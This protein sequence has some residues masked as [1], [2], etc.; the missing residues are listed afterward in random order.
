MIRV[1]G[2]R[3]AE[4]LK[5]QDEDESDEEMEE[6]SASEDEQSQEEDEE[7]EEDE[8]SEE[9]DDGG[10][11]SQQQQQQKEKK[12]KQQGAVEEEESEGEDEGSESDDEGLDDEGL[13]DDAMMAMDEKLGA[14]VRGVLSRGG[15][16]GSARQ[17][18]AA[19]LHL[20]LRVAALLE[21]WCKKV[22]GLGRRGGTRDLAFGGSCTAW[23]EGW[24]NK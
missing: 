1:L 17:R 11:T 21:E 9:G 20:Q 8:E 12:K 6:G 22:R 18:Q 13:D 19:L 5:D 10:K 3:A 14:A 15:A 24:G 23:G 4:V 7:P 2:Q 16:G